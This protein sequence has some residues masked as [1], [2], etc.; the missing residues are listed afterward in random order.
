LIDTEAL[1]EALVSGRLAG[2][3]LDVLEEETVIREEAQLLFEELPSKKLETA[4]Y[5][6][7]LLRQK[8]V[9]ITP[10]CGFN[11]AESLQRLVNTTIENIRC[12]TNGKP[13]NVV[14]KPTKLQSSKMTVAPTA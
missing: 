4:L 5:E 1:T 6:H 14:N 13:Q 2:A 12:F 10:H 9:I 3:G 11:S 7:V 8:N